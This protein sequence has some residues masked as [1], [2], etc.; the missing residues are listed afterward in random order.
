MFLVYVEPSVVLVSRADWHDWLNT[1]RVWWPVEAR[2]WYGSVKNGFG[3]RCLCVTGAVPRQSQLG[4]R[5]Q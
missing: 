2:W 3:K 5:Y 1:A 4:H